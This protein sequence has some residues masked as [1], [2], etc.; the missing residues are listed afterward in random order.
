MEIDSI[1]KSNLFPKIIKI[2]CSNVE[3]IMKNNGFCKEIATIPLSKENIG[4][5]LYKTLQNYTFMPIPHSFFNRIVNLGS[6]FAFKK[7]NRHVTIQQKRTSF[8]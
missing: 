4:T 3:P 1:K 7:Y 6:F 5:Y 8:T 2:L